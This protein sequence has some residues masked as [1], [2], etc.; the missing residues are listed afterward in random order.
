MCVFK[1][2]VRCQRCEAH[3]TTTPVPQSAGTGTPSAPN[4]QA[5]DWPEH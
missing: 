5:M 3:P 4:A 1:G 2:V